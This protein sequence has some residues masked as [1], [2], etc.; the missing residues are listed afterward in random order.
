[1]ACGAFACSSSP[2]C[3]GIRG[4]FAACRRTPGVRCHPRLWTGGPGAPA[5]QGHA[6]CQNDRDR[7]SLLWR[8]RPLEAPA[9]AA[10]RCWMARPHQADRQV[11]PSRRAARVG[12]N[13]AV[14]RRVRPGPGG[15][16]GRA[17]IAE[18]HAHAVR[19]VPPF[20]ATGREVDPAGRVR[21]TSRHRHLRGSR[22]APFGSALLVLAPLSTLFGY[23]LLTPFITPRSWSRVLWTYL[24]P[25]VPLA[26]CW[27]GV[28]SLLRVYS[29]R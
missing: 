9:A 15:R 20:R 21:E 1:M 4:P 11:P 13:I 17:A 14:G 7:R 16:A 29:P 19:G 3:P 24:I 5:G 8:R 18:G 10:R 26:T 28:V 23:L 6:A 25:V 27:D 22:A 12:G 2:I